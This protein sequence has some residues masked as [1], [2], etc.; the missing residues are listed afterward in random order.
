[1]AIMLDP[2]YNNGN[3]TAQPKAG[4]RTQSAMFDLLITRTPVAVNSM[5]ADKAA[6][7]LPFEV[8]QEDA[9]VTGKF[10]AND[11][12]W[13]TCAYDQHNVGGGTPYNGDYK[14]ALASIK[15]KTMILQAGLDLLNPADEGEAAAKLIPGAVHV[16]IQSTLPKGDNRLSRP[17]K[18]L[19]RTR[20]AA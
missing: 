4:W 1:M 2:V 14:A 11:W 5:F 17:L 9:C 18:R 16:T 7:V 10:D 15:A 6:D 12:I 19:P 8:K 3:Y 20:K 13:Q